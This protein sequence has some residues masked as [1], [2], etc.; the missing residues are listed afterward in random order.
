MELALDKLNAE[1][2]LHKLVNTAVGQMPFGGGFVNYLV[3]TVIF[4]TPEVDLWKEVEGKVEK[5]LA[6][7][8]DQVVSSLAASSATT[9]FARLRSFGNQLRQIAYVT[10]RAE[11]KQRMA[12]MLAVL[13]AALAECSAL[14]GAYSL[15]AP[16]V[17]RPLSLAHVAILLDLK[18]MEPHRYEHQSAL[19]QTAILYSDLAGKLFQ[20]AMAWRR[21]MIGRGEG[22]LH[23]WDSNVTAQKHDVHIQVY[24]K[25][26]NNVWQPGE[27]GVSI[28]HK[29]EPG[30]WSDRVDVRYEDLKTRVYAELTAYDQKVQTEFTALWNT[31]LL[32]YTKGFMNLVDWPGV[33]REKK[34]KATADARVVTFP[35]IPTPTAGMRRDPLDRLDLFLEQQMDQFA[36]AGPRY[37]QTYRLPAEA[38]TGPHAIMHT[39]ADTYDT[40]VACIYFQERGRMDRAADLADALV[41][42]LNHDAKG[43][44]RIV[45]AT[46]ADELLD[47]GMASTTSIFVHDGGRRD[48]GNMSWA[49]LAL[50]RMYHRTGRYRYLHAAETIGRWILS[51]CAVGDDWGGFSGGEDQWGGKYPWRSVEHN[52]DAFSLFA[53]LHHLTGEAPWADASASAR[54]LVLACRVQ[55]NAIEMY[56]VTGTKETKA[57]N[58]GVIPT[59]TQSWTA[60]AG[61]DPGPA[62]G[63]SLAYMLHKMDATSAG[64][65]GTKFA[66]HGAEVQNEATAG[67][68]MALWLCGGDAMRPAAQRYIDSLV[69]QIG[70]AKNGDGYGVVAT[71]APEAKTGPGLGWSYFNFLHVASSA[72]TGLALLARENPGANPYA[73]L[74]TVGH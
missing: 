25:F 56:Y 20:R 10:D 13:D 32:N 4:P 18:A 21:T 73:P 16:D 46:R 44:G 72:W 69:R 74:P 5:L 54:K 61:I 1:D 11:R 27:N 12:A 65:P 23:I 42:A 58:D 59:D 37:V 40:A 28:I 67:A 49:G 68:A 64:F 17:L 57:L 43:G 8:M 71:P 22:Y 35:V 30:L 60:L 39:R 48:V 53:N 45:A 41:A 3:D 34:G 47:R 33:E 2:V 7:R 29:T 14:P 24:D 19:N 6:Q 51:N 36:V 70:S 52:V 50:T 55:R 31:K 66:E 9:L 38:L 26:W 63:F 15:T 62:E